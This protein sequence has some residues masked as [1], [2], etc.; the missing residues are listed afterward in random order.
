M[1][2]FFEA[3]TG[4][5]RFSGVQNVRFF[6]LGPFTGEAWLCYMQLQP[7]GWAA[8]GGAFSV[9]V[10]PGSALNEATHI[11]GAKLFSPA[12]LPALLDGRFAPGETLHVRGLMETMQWYLWHYLDAGS[13]YVHV[14]WQPWSLNN[15]CNV[16]ANALTVSKEFMES[17]V[18]GLGGRGVGG[19]GVLE[20]LS[21]RAA[22]DIRSGS[23]P[24]VVGG[25]VAGG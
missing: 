5:D 8:G 6:V 13:W 20:V 14:A 24:D 22:A 10:G 12:P 1:P 21:G 2:R 16:W 3:K 9:T 11:E 25:A 19:P 15:V 7:T 17:L 23:G 4:G 18:G